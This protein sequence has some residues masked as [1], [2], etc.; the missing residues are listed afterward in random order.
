MFNGPT[1]SA[2]VDCLEIKGIHEY[3]RLQ[4]LKLHVVFQMMD[5]LAK[6][7]TTIRARARARRPSP[8]P[9]PLSKVK[10]ANAP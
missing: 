10:D 9:N 3:G 5:L 8:S 2:L 1:K 6:M 4:I 7:R